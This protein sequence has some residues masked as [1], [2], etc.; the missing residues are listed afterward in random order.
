VRLREYAAVVKTAEPFDV[1]SL[2]TATKAWLERTGL[3]MKDFAQPA[4]VALTGRTASPGL[5]EVMAILGKDR[6]LSRLEA[7]AAAGE[8]GAA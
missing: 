6:S 5:Y 8:R 2:E 7:G 3:T 1:P 4:R